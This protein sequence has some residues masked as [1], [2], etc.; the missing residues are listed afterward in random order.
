MH[1]IPQI[2]PSNLMSNV[3]ETLRV[4]W[5]KERICRGQLGGSSIL[6][7][8]LISSSRCV[9]IP[10]LIG[11][12]Q[13]GSLITV[14]RHTHTHPH[15]IIKGIFTS[16]STICIEGHTNTG[17]AWITLYNLESIVKTAPV[18]PQI[19][20]MFVF[21][22]YSKLRY[23]CAYIWCQCDWLLISPLCISVCHCSCLTA[24]HSH[25]SFSHGAHRWKRDLCVINW[26]CL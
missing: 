4:L 7:S 13:W 18:E 3:S 5:L 20:I 11:H 14:C 19:L 9:L 26:I 17:A 22:S 12:E 16:R 10:L 6:L 21:R 23:E 24:L 15:R 8:C 2:Y 25:L 1:D